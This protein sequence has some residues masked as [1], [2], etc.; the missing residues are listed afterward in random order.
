M[1]TTSYRVERSTIVDAPPE[2][3]YP[4]LADFR[5]W[6]SWS[7][8][9]GVDPT[10]TRTYSGADAGAGAVYAW[11]GNRKAGAGRMTITEVTPPWRVA[12]DLRFDKPFRSRSET[13]FTV[14][15]A[16]AGCRVTWT[17]TG[18]MSVGTRLMSLVK[19]MDALI[20]P[21]FEK[22]LAHLK[23]TAETTRG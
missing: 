12:V 1:A 3:V 14:E 23:L 6:T 5:R 7:P 16:G 18:P 19:S 17:M 8:W 9:E 20:G 15:P 2:A 11:T 10:M 13:V 22:G 21:D 4:H